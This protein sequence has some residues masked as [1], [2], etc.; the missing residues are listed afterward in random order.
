MSI[1]VDCVENLHNA[2]YSRREIDEWLEQSNIISPVI[3]PNRDHSAISKYIRNGKDPEYTAHCIIRQHYE[4]IS[5]VIFFHHKYKGLNN[6]YKKY[7]KNE[8]SKFHVD[9]SDINAT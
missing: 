5:N 9:S 1:L 4:K 2:N 3:F 6:F 8:K 7:I